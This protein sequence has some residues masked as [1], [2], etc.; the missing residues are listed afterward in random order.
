MGELGK[1]DGFGVAPAMGTGFKIEAVGIELN[2]F[3]QGINDRRG[4]EILVVFKSGHLANPTTEAEQSG[5]A[6]ASSP[7]RQVRW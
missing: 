4:R 1:V 7:Q 2:L 5:A 3:Q 6:F